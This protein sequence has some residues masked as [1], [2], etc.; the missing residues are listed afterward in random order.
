M[1]QDPNP[2][3]NPPKDGMDSVAREQPDWPLEQVK[4]LAL[5]LYV[6]CPFDD[7]PDD[8]YWKELV[9]K[10]FWVLDNLDETCKQILRERSEDRKEDAR[11]RDAHKKLPPIVPFDKAVREI[12]SEK[13]N[14]RA[15]SNFMKFL[16]YKA[17]EIPF[18]GVSP[19]LSAAQMRQLQAQVSKWE[20]KGIIRER[21]LEMQSRFKRC[22]ADVRAEQN[23]A[24]RS[25]HKRRA[26][27][28]D[29]RKTQS[30]IAAVIREKNDLT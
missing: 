29:D 9:R 20:D 17:R 27:F 10:A 15:R 18:E 30:I 24:N 13:H 25:S 19:S 5:E 16:S 6:R 4:Q 21:V 23:S 28:P 7:D 8:E 14:D 1:K 22:W 2:T 26:R 3:P 12:T 11:V